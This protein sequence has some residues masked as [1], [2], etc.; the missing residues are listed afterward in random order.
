MNTLD[1]MVNKTVTQDAGCD[2]LRYVE[3][4][5]RLSMVRDHFTVY[6]LQQ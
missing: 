3:K 6:D 5:C 4:G 2:A 1:C